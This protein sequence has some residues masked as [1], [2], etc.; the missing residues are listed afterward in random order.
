LEEK[1]RSLNIFAKA[2]VILYDDG[3]NI[4]P[5]LYPGIGVNTNPSVPFVTP[6]T[7]NL[8]ITFTEP[9]SSDVFTSPVY[10]PF[11]FANKTRST[12]IHLPNFPPTSLAN[13]GLFNT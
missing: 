7:I 12:E 11:I 8:V 9:I 1:I 6:D 5:Q 10:N 13:T 2:V 3:Y 4:L